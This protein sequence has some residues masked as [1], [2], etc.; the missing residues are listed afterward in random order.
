MEQ[1]DHF[2]DIDLWLSISKDRDAGNLWR[3]A[4]TVFGSLLQVPQPKK[5]QRQ[6]EQPDNFRGRPSGEHLS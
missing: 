1:G 3:K 6:V 4:R 5:R 2:R